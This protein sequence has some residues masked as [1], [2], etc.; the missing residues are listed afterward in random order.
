MEDQRILR[1][2][3]VK[4]IL[5]IGRTTLWKI[6]NEDPTFPPKDFITSKN[7]GFRK[8]DFEKWFLNKIDSENSCN[9]SPSF[10]KG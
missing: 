10:N 6:I 4:L 3:E 2:K 5:G 1:L 7:Y 8:C 9:L